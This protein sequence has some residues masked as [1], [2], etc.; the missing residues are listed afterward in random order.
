ME[1]KKIKLD[2]EM[3]IFDV[4]DL[5]KSFSSAKILIA[6][7]GRNRNRSDIRKEA[8]LDALPSIRNIPIV[9]RYDVESL[10][11]DFTAF[12]TVS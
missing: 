7:T 5:N 11:T 2:F 1:N 3:T 12:V 4:V 10:F 8:F 9:G 6:Y